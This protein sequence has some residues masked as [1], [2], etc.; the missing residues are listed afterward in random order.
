MLLRSIPP[1]AT[2]PISIPPRQAQ[3]SS[4]KKVKESYRGFKLD[5]LKTAILRNRS[6]LKL[7]S[8][9]DGGDGDF[10]WEIE[11]D[12]EDESGSPWEGAIVY[13]R[14][15]STSHLEYCT[16]L[17]RLGLGKVSSAASR[18]RASDMGLRVV[19]SV[20]EYPDGTPVLISVDVDRR[21]QR[22]RLDGIVR[23]VL[24][25][26]CNRCGE[27]AAQGVYSD[28]SL[29]LHEQPVQEPEIIDMG[30][31]FGDNKS[32]NFKTEDG[33]DEEALIDIEDQ[34]YFPQ[35][36]KRIDI[37]KN[38][39]DLIHVEIT[40]SA[41][42][43]PNCKGLCFNCGANLNVSQCTC[44][45]NRKELRAS[46]SNGVLRVGF[47]SRT[48]IGFLLFMYVIFGLCHEV[49]IELI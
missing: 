34:L 19:K 21:R 24:G 16:T 20:K 25:L 44:E 45:N 6:I 13:E 39:R 12:G 10:D 11:I 30:T 32:K 2:I 43:N 15:A 29:L 4:C 40:I 33:T 49:L 42:C 18:S 35:E 8:L 14:D 1:L 26:D 3:F 22:L 41:V 47:F 17:E 48:F 9:P 46:S 23:T 36:E 37:S 5:S 27:P 7:R 38:I 28:F 31:I